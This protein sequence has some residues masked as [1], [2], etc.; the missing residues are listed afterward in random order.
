MLWPSR[1]CKTCTRPDD[2]VERNPVLNHLITNDLRYDARSAFTLS[3]NH[4]ETYT[5]ITDHDRALTTRRFAEL[6]T[7]CL[8]DGVSGEPAMKMLGEEFRT[9][10]HIP[11]CREAK[12]GLGVRQGHT[13]LAVGLARL[14]GTLL[15]SSVLRCSNP[16]ATMPFL[17]LMPEHG[18]KQGAYR[19]SKALMSSPHLALNHYRHPHEATTQ[20]V[21]GGPMKRILAVGVFDLLHAGHLHYLEQAKAFG[22]HL[23]V[24]VAHDD[25]VRKRKHEPVTNQDLRRRM[26]AGL[27][28]VDEPWWSATL[29][30]CLF[31]TFFPR[32]SR[33]SSHWATTKSM[34]KKIFARHCTSEATATSTWCGLKA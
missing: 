11:V 17:S 15:S 25:T 13:E 5:G 26:V 23:T 4:R 1:S 24:V 18:L 21:I 27:K 20:P 10:G 3:I 7:T 31:L 34:R 16:M 29:P 22:D 33:T 12:G 28:P 9:P 8:S 30:T 2:A 14:A 32:F 6:A 19:S